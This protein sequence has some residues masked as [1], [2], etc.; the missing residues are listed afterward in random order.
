MK[1]QLTTYAFADPDLYA[2]MRRLLNLDETRQGAVSV[3]PGQRAWQEFDCK[4]QP[5]HRRIQEDTQLVPSATGHP[6]WIIFPAPRSIAS[7]P[8]SFSLRKCSQR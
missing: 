1:Y 3:H 4:G 5:S 7:L 6:L 2:E 8:H